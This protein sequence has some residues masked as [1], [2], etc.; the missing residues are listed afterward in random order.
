MVLQ[1][2]FVDVGLTEIVSQLRLHLFRRITLLD[3]RRL[4]AVH[5]VVPAISHKLTIVLGLILT[6]IPIQRHLLTSL[7]LGKTGGGLDECQ[8]ADITLRSL[9]PRITEGQRGSSTLVVKT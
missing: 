7:Q 6:D 1:R 3:C 5:A 4:D 9:H 8:L 2:I